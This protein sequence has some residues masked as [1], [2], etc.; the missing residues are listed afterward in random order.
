M[1]DSSPRT[2]NLLSPRLRSASALPLASTLTDTP[3]ILQSEETDLESRCSF[4]NT[5]LNT[6]VQKLVKFLLINLSFSNLRH[7]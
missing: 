7:L 4:K 5:K 2:S 3:L 1:N 6:S